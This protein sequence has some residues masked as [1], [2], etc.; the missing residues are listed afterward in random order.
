MIKWVLPHQ[1]KNKELAVCI[2]LL[3]AN[4]GNPHMLHFDITVTDVITVIV[5]FKSHP[6][7][8]ICF[9][10]YLAIVFLALGYWVA[11]KIGDDCEFHSD[12]HILW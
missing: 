10:L 8:P 6:T 11:L 12:L 7:H 1:K 4:R 9:L 3:I 5:Y 2:S